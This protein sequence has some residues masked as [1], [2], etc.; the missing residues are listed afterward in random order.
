MA[1]LLE[2]GYPDYLKPIAKKLNKKY[3]F[4]EEIAPGRNGITY[5]LRS[6]SNGKLYCLK[7]ISPTIAGSTDRNRVR[8]TLKNEVEILGPLTHRCLPTIYEHDIREVFP[9]YVCTYHPG[10]TWESFRLSGKKL[11]LSEAIFVI[12]SLIDVLEYIHETGRTHCDLHGDN[13]LISEKVLGEGI[14]VIDFGSGHRGSKDTPDTYD[15]GHGG[16]KNIK[17]QQQ[18]RLQVRRLESIANFR[19]YD[20]NA[21]GK[22][23]S[24]MQEAFFST[25]PHDQNI[26]YS[27]FCNMLQDGAIKKWSDVRE[28]FAHVVDPRLFLT[29]LEHLFV[30]ENGERSQIII[31][32]TMPVPVGAAVLEVINHPTFQRLRS[33]KQLSF[34]EWQ[35]PGGTHTRFEHS[36]GVFGVTLKALEFLGRDPAI[37]SAFSP[38]HMQ[39]TLLA[40]L[41][42]DVG[43]YPFAHAI[44]HYVA[45]RV[46]EDKD[47]HEEVKKHTNHFHH[48]LDILEEQPSNSP[49]AN[50]SRVVRKSWGEEVAEEAKSVLKGNAGVLSQIL[51]GPVD[52]DKID[53]LKRDSW[54]C[55]LPYGGFNVEE[56]LSSFHPSPDGKRLL[57]RDSHIHAIEGFMIAQDQ[58]LAAVYWQETVRAVFAMFH[59]FL[60]GTV[61]NDKNQMI[62]LVE[63]LKGCDNDYQAL[64]NVFL[65]MLK[66][67]KDEAE[68]WPLIKLHFQPSFLDIYRPIRRFCFDEETNPKLSTSTNVFD[69]IINSSINTSRS[70]MPINRKQVQRLV[71]SFRKAFK[72]KAADKGQEPGKYEVLVDVPWGK[73]AN[74]MLSVVDENGQNEKEI[75]RRSHLAESIFKSITA[76]SAPIRVFVS[77]RL[78]EENAHQ[79][80]S[81]IAS[82]LEKYFDVR[83]NLEEAAAG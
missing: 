81:I 43:H 40:A 35:F 52:C 34:C 16:F 66:G 71:Q 76:F 70:G 61:G 58:M 80:E 32:A 69:T 8:A 53:Y 14:L 12:A 7:T 26:A 83:T 1:D 11:Q 63:Q 79:L 50:F 23:L 46:F 48:S 64:Q 13:I 44:E 74:R 17:G 45:G 75:T 20:F 57:V 25:A 73:N 9:Y 5:K 21:L 65:P 55:G 39:A 82:A 30:K 77:P 49:I 28:R 10:Q 68:L 67:S 59:G 22:A 38:K 47:A 36:L 54:H 15:R 51:D 2:K 78:F 19:D 72:E 33:I 56:I 60:A 42:H 27:D 29:R 62:D 31:P 4:I 37:K 3:E 24:G 6:R 18:H 41:V